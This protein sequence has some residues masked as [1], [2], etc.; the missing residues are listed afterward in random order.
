M[1]TKISQIYSAVYTGLEG[2][3]LGFHTWA[4]FTRHTGDVPLSAVEGVSLFRRFVVS[5]E[6]WQHG[7]TYDSTSKSYHKTALVIE[8]GYPAVLSDPDGGVNQ[9]G[10]DAV[11]D[12][13]VVRVLQYLVH[14]R[15]NPL[16]ALGGVR[17]MTQLS[18]SKI[19]TA[20]TVKIRVG[21]RWSEAKPIA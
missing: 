6:A 9:V 8:A 1:A 11:I 4:P 14:Q 18:P 21:L 17:A 16:V 13:D 5:T 2:L 3:T 19:R 10:I 15:P 7:D 12:D 20:N